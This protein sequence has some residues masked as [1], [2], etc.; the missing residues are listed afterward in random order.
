MILFSVVPQ[1]YLRTR[2]GQL[3]LSD[4]DTLIGRSRT[5]HLVL[6]DPSVSRNHSLLIV[7]AGELLVKDLGSTN[8]SYVNGRR[9]EGVLRLHSGDRLT[10]GESDFIIGEV[11]EEPVEDPGLVTRRVDAEELQCSSCGAPL[12]LTVTDCPGCGKSLLDEPV[13]ETSA[14]T[15]K[16]AMPPGFVGPS[17]AP[18]P[19]AEAEP[20]EPGPEAPAP[21]APPEEPSR[22]SGEVLPVV[23]LGV[24]PEVAL[25]PE[26]AEQPSR[27]AAPQPSPLASVESMP[28]PTPGPLPAGF[29]VRAAAAFLDGLLIVLLS[30][31]VSLLQ[32]GPLT[33]A[34]RSLGAVVVVVLGVLIPV[35]GWSLWGTTPGKAVLRL[36]VCDL[37]GRVGISPARALLRLL[38]YGGGILSLGIGFVMM[39][40]TEGKRGLHDV[41]AGT[42]VGYR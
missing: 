24:A 36:V 34:G 12:D 20:R 32:G 17:P 29:W 1:F 14:P 27:A 26:P 22:E 37:H 25:E 8:G 21:E 2:T 30:T 28:T 7:Q 4:G 19:A 16:R 11:G 33:E 38:G 10:I 18:A 31:A 42:Y 5:C 3:D 35:F 13:P 41:L 39:A 15:R 9:L 6:K 23:D 40:F